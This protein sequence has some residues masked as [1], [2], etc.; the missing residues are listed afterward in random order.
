MGATC[1]ICSTAF[2]EIAHK[3]GKE[4][5]NPS[6][7]QYAAQ[8][9]HCFLRPF[10]YMGGQPMIFFL[11]IITFVNMILILPMIGILRILFTLFVFTGIICSIIEFNY[12]LK[13]G[14][15]P[16]NLVSSVAIVNV[17]G[18]SVTCLSYCSYYLLYTTFNES[19]D[20]NVGIMISF[21]YPTLSVTA[22]PY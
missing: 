3:K 21:F 20:E 22:N 15:R 18:Y 14:F 13:Y 10:T 19:D 17:I 12:V 4:Q 11:W 6:L 8:I 5:I 16:R 1:P 9:Q 2:S 7:K